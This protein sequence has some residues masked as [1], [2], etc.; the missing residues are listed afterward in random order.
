M[1]LTHTYTSTR[2][3]KRMYVVRSVFEPIWNEIC[4]THIWNQM[5]W[6]RMCR[7][8]RQRRRY[9]VPVT[10][11]RCRMRGVAK[12]RAFQATNTHSAT[13]NQQPACHGRYVFKC[14][15]KACER[16][17]VHTHTQYTLGRIEWREY[18]MA[19]MMGTENSQLVNPHTRGF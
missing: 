4:R 12:R 5:E 18:E 16:P 9:M 19:T 3:A 17:Q 7:N 10:C 8:G 1:R 11:M 13:S 14:G 15:S 6:M 2:D